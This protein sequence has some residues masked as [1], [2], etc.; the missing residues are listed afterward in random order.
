[1]TPDCSQSII[2]FFCQDNVLVKPFFQTYFCLFLFSQVYFV[3]LTGYSSRLT[4]IEP[5]S[6]HIFFYC[7]TS[8]GDV[9]FRLLNTVEIII[10]LNSEDCCN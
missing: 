2:R 10:L 5:T 4:G 8:A 9:E 6:H 3:T 1:M 7:D